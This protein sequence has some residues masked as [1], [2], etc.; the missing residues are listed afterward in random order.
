MQNQAEYMLVLTTCPDSQVAQ[1]IAGKIVDAKLA[2][3]VNIVPKIISV[4]EWQGKKEQSEESLLFIKT[5]QDKYT[6]LQKCIVNEHPYELPEVIAVP[7]SKGLP[8]YLAWISSS[9][10]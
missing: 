7:I 6:A 2:A 10:N 9:I 4:Y 1:F 3:C 8:D 5:T